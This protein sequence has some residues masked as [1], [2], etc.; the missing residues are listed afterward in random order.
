M[1]IFCNTRHIAD[2]SSTAYQAL[3]GLTIGDEDQI[4]NGGKVLMSNLYQ[5]GQIDEPRFGLA[6]GTNGTGSFVL[7]GVDHSLFDGDLTHTPVV[8]G[9]WM[10]L[11]SLTSEGSKL[12]EQQTLWLDSGGPSVSTYSRDWTYARSI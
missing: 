2:G 1:V 10:V 6:L 12:V 8:G 4:G 11:A 3:A 5:S 9:Q 7:G